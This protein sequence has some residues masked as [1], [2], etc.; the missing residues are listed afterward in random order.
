MGIECFHTILIV[1]NGHNP[2]NIS[3]FLS[4]VGMYIWSLVN[5][6]STCCI[7]F[8]GETDAGASLI[9][10]IKPLL[11]E[12]QQLFDI[13]EDELSNDPEIKRFP[14]AVLS[15]IAALCNLMPSET[16]VLSLEVSKTWSIQ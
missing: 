5:K 6:T 9:E 1:M 4:K 15:N 16:N 2:N 7:R 11:D 3:N 14:Q 12:F 8:A 13:E 10:H